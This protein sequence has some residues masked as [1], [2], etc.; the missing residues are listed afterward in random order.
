MLV[1]LESAAFRVPKIVFHEGLNVIIGDPSAANSIGKSTLLMVI[2]FVFGG[3]SLLESS[4]DIIRNV[5]E[6]SYRFKF[7]FAGRAHYFM[8]STKTKELVDKCDSTYVVTKTISLSDYT[9]WLAEAYAIVG[10]G[11][12]FRAMVGP[13]SRVWPKENV[14]NVHRPLH[15]DP[16]QSANDCIDTLTKL[17]GRFADVQQSSAAF[18]EAENKRKVWRK[19][20][21]LNYVPKISRKEY[22]ANNIALESIGNEVTEIKKNLAQYALN[23]RA[24]VDREVMDLAQNK[25]MLLRERSKIQQRL[26]R[27]QQNLRSNKHV[28]SSQLDSLKDFFPNI[29]VDKVV[30]IEEFHSAVAR[31]LKKELVQTETSLKSQLESLDVAIAQIDAQVATRLSDYENPNAIVDRVY[32]L[33]ERWQGLKNANRSYER[34]SSLDLAYEK[35]KQELEA[36]KQEIL[37]EIEAKINAEL[38]RLVSEIYG[39]GANAPKLSLGQNSY[40]YE[41]ADDTGT[42]TAFANLLLFDLAILSLTELPF[43]I[44]DLPLFKNVENDA[45]AAFVVEYTKF[46]AKQ[47]FT[48]LDEIEKYGETTVDVLRRRCILQ[49]TEQDVLYQKKWH[50]R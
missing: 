25:D 39:Q 23:L 2:D 49:L 27:T 50:S 13:Y 6:H 41:I 11:L 45:V 19:A 18:Q 31:L 43:L 24:I 37:D 15:A 48:V 33:S 44:H 3:N 12:S 16:H 29:Q 47:I 28:K 30:Q 5:G 9:S 4:D 17:F 20:G 1:E 14:T 42:G 34:S 7:C 38:A 46:P 26:I 8:R 36:V 22:A 35:T 10:K 21:G 40:K 32:Q